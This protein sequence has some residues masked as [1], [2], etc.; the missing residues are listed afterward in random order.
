MFISSKYEGLVLLPEFW[1]ILVNI[2]GPSAYFS[3][4][5]FALKPWVQAG[6]FEYHE[7]YNRNSYYYYKLIIASASADASADL[8]A[9]IPE[10]RF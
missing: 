4:P 1:H 5:I 6:C 10:N 8:S 9:D 2:S 7:P 3:K